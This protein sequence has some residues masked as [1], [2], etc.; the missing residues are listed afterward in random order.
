MKK[1]K[2]FII[3]GIFCLVG[4][5]WAAGPAKAQETTAFKPSGKIFVQFFGDYYYKMSGSSK[6]FSHAQYSGTAN[7]FNAFD[8]R[9]VYFGYAYNFTSDIS[10][11]I[12][13]ANE[14]NYLP[15]G[16][17]A[18]YIKDAEVKI[19][20][21][22]PYGNLVVGHT[23]TPTFAMYSEHIWGYRSVEK[24]LLDMRKF[25]GSNDLGIQLS[26]N[27][28][29]NGVVGYT[30]M[31]GNGTGAKIENNKYKKMYAELHAR[32]FNKKIFLEGYTDYEGG[33]GKTQKSTVKGFVAYDVPTFTLGLAAVSQSQN[34]AIAPGINSDPSGFWVFTHGALVKDHLNGFAR[35]DL[36]NPDKS[37]NY[38]ETFALLGLDYLAA[39]NVHFMPNI[40]INSYSAK[41]GTD[42]SQ[43]ADVVGRVTFYYSF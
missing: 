14:G 39:K 22:I 11:K 35:L 3:A 2:V 43:K 23:G 28:D 13:L 42:P 18:F 31:I 12:E 16:T 9:R 30:L 5:L 37:S 33:P 19:N 36:Y 32:L 8:I 21:I 40:W 34:N 25:G 29:K 4:G 17:R 20:N 10:A 6:S 15:D 41:H 1:R 38:N 27:F 26:G 7:N 24:T